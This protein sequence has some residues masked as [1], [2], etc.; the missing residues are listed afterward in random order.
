MLTSLYKLNSHKYIWLNE[1]RIYVKTLWITV[2]LLFWLP[3]S[4]KCHCERSEAI[5]LRYV[6]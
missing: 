2:I 5:S 3:P 6:F 4:V 1:L